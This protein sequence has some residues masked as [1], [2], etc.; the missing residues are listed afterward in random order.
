[1]LL[2]PIGARDKSRIGTRHRGPRV[3]NQT[4]EC[5]GLLQWL[6]R[7]PGVA[8]RYSGLGRSNRQTASHSD[9]ILVKLGDLQR[10]V[11]FSHYDHDLAAGNPR[12]GWAYTLTIADLSQVVPEPMPACTS[13]LKE[14]WGRNWSDLGKEEESV[15]KI[16]S[17]I[18]ECREVAL[19]IL[20]ELR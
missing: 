11:F 1:V 9:E 16:G 4:G 17:T 20:R 3:I 19:K 7:P 8:R 10:V 2:R 12:S 18:D 6:A 14:A 5:A 13:R 15:Q